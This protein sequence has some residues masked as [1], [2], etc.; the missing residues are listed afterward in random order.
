MTNESNKERALTDE[1]L[2][3]ARRQAERKAASAKRAAERTVA[4]AD[5]Q[6]EATEKEMMAAAQKRLEHETSLITADIPHQKQIRTLRVRSEVVD[7][8]FEQSLQAVRERRDADRLSVLVRLSV[9]AVA[10]IEGDSVTLELSPQDAR[11]LGNALVQKVAEHMKA[12]GRSVQITAAASPALA[13]GVVVKS[14]DGRTMVDNS[15]AAR[16]RRVRQ[17]LRGKIAALIFG[18]S[19]E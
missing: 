16:L 1:I 7:G 13:G 11:E 5:K 18:E 4:S 12:S 19:T 8:L 10:V 15:F 14:G 9:G 2:A 3:D 17:D 6:I